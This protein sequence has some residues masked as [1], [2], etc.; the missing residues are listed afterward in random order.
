[1]AALKSY[2]NIHF[3][4]V[5]LYDFSVGTIAEKWIK[6]DLILSSEFHFTHLSD[7]LRLITLNKFG[8]IYF[9]TNFVF[10][11]RFVGPPNFGGEIAPD[12]ISNAVIGFDSRFV[13][14]T[15][16]EMVLRYSILIFP[17]FLISLLTSLW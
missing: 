13:G 14:H 1:M 3:R 12:L 6:K 4:N 5:N 11:K 10:Q 7:Y 16:V 15:I 8:G 2:P 9:D 17:P